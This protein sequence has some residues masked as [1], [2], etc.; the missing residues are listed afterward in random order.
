[1]AKEHEAQVMAELPQMQ[2]ALHSPPFYATSCNYFG[3]IRVKIGRDKRNKQYGVI[4]TCLNT[5]AVHMELATDLST[6]DVP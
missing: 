3:P 1:M 6:I 5:R 4:F 2:L